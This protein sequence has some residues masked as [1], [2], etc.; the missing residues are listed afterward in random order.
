[1]P[2][3]APH[4]RKSSDD[5][6]NGMKAKQ[7]SDETAVH[8]LLSMVASLK[9]G[10]AARKLMAKHQHSS[11]SQETQQVS[12]L[13][14]DMNIFAGDASSE[15]LNAPIAEEVPEAAS[16]PRPAANI[17][18]EVPEAVSASAPRKKNLF[19]DSLTSSL[20]R[21]P[22]K[23]V[24]HV[25]ALAENSYLKEFDLMGDS[26]TAVKAKATHAFASTSSNK[27]MNSWFSDLSDSS[28]EKAK[29]EEKPRV[30]K[31]S[32]LMSWLDPE[33]EEKPARKAP[34]MAEA[35]VNKYLIDLS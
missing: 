5:Y 35:P 33:P 3:A 6:T 11:S 25:A 2:G 8:S 15:A 28:E 16:A 20:G 30:N 10:K 22:E 34:V 26:E 4:L 7:N 17:A 18:E 23:K 19:L 31:D 9:G 24:H 29:K 14:N 1:M 32:T 12:S 13:S 27:I 21:T